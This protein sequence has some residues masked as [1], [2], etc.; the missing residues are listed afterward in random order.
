MKHLT[1]CL[2][3]LL[4]A[5]C[6]PQ[7]PTAPTPPVHATP[8]QAAPPTHA[9]SSGAGTASMLEGLAGAL[10]GDAVGLAVLDL[11]VL[12]GELNA[13]TSGLFGEHFGPTE[14]AA[15]K[16]DLS[17]L[18]VQRTGL[19][20]MQAEWTAISMGGERRNMGW[21]ALALGGTFDL[22]ALPSETFGGLTVHKTKDGE[23]AIV[24]LENPKGVL[25]LN[26]GQVE[27]FAKARAAG[28]LAAGPRFA[29]MK[30]AVSGAG[31]GFLIVAADLEH[32]AVNAAISEEFGG[33]LI[34][35]DKTRKAVEDF[36]NL[37][38]GVTAIAKAET[39][40]AKEKAALDAYL[41]QNAKRIE[42]ARAAD[43]GAAEKLMRK[44]RELGKAFWDAL[45]EAEST[46]GECS[47]NRRAM[48]R[49]FFDITDSQGSPTKVEGLYIATLRIDAKS[50]RLA[51]TGSV[52]TLTI[53]K[54]YA[55]SAMG[56]VRKELDQALSG[57]DQAPLP[58]A[59][60][61]T[62][63]KHL[64][65]PITAA[66]TPTLEG[67]TLSLTI[68]TPGNPSVIGLLVAT[69][70][71]A[72]MFMAGSAKVASGNNLNPTEL[73]ERNEKPENMELC[74]KM[75]KSIKDDIGDE[76]WAAFSQCVDGQTDD[77][78]KMVA[79][80]EEAGIQ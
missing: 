9:P 61:L 69:G 35:G 39:D 30:K 23:A 27:S 68:P 25:L 16:A 76:K 10:P 20:F 26:P 45:Y 51:V 66:L 43:I 77:S 79:C 41:E 50:I 78:E 53:L 49:T 2:A 56:D 73:C 65:E 59:L 22:S 17:K 67:D 47:D 4:C 70:M 52:P 29:K 60:S 11:S 18:F 1:W 13:L 64:V 72:G 24:P 46:L 58:E 8:S 44:D 75:M 55:A 7:E 36:T 32:P 6:S 19:D 38:Q 5:A 33:M 40:C 14:Q 31:A 71:G 28:T 37:I 48:S 54:G 62:L 42:A 12:G 74:I 34:A 80:F 63:A 57:I 3:V 15:L 21:I